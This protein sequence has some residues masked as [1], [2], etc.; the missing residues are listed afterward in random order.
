[1]D[2][3]QKEKS[4]QRS[5]NPS[6]HEK[7]VMLAFAGMTG[8]ERLFAQP[9]FPSIFAIIRANLYIINLIQSF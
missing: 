5:R 3:N 1:V 2:F 9:D 6:F 7:V 8:L 4:G